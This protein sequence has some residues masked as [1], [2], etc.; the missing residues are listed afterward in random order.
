MYSVAGAPSANYITGGDKNKI[1]AVMEKQLTRERVILLCSM[2][3]VH[4]S[5]LNNMARGRDPG[6]NFSG[7][8]RQV[9]ERCYVGK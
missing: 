5:A 9:L 7:Q 3:K 4:V 8:L 6:P 1:W 2:N